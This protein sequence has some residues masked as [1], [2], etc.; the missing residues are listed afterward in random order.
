MFTQGGPGFNPQGCL[1]DFLAPVGTCKAKGLMM[2]MTHG[3]VTSVE[4]VRKLSRQQ[5]A[6]AKAKA[7]AAGKHNVKQQP[8]GDQS[9]LAKSRQLVAKARKALEEAGGSG[10]G[11]IKAGTPL[12]QKFLELK[13]EEGLA[14]AG[15]T[16]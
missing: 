12:H 3:S 1:A 8:R 2:T 7:R 16:S 5:K 4:L 9:A 14:Q 13:A 6:N 11:R 10:K 15:S